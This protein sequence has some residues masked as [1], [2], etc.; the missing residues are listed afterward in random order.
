MLTARPVREPSADASATG[1]PSGQSDIRAQAR[2][3]R[4]RRREH[5]PLEAACR[6]QVAQRIQSQ[7][8]CDRPG[9]RYEHTACAS[10]PAD[11][12]C[13]SEDH[14]RATDEDRGREGT[15][16]SEP[17]R[18]DPRVPATE[19]MGAQRRAKRDA[20][21]NRGHSQEQ[22]GGKH[23]SRDRHGLNHGEIRGALSQCD[24]LDTQTRSA[25]VMRSSPPM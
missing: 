9:C 8:C 10:R 2:E 24:P 11:R 7:E 15:E 12:A 18:E 22:N 4:G 1:T 5:G 3:D 19:Y 21:L 25:A 17:I 14:E 20:G 23:G 13:P 6:C 16:G